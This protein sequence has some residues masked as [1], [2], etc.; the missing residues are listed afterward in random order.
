MTTLITY[1]IYDLSNPHFQIT[2]VVLKSGHI[3][4]GQFVQ[5]KV[6][7]GLVE[8]LYPSEKYCFLPEENGREFWQVSNNTNGEFKD[9]PAYIKLLSLNDIQKITIH[10][11]LVV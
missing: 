9:F 11:A 2:E 6:V 8:Y 7:K 10:P 1:P 4:K 5:F 3:L